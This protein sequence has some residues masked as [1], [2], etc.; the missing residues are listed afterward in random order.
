VTPDQRR[1]LEHAAGARIAKTGA[2]TGGCIGE[3]VRVDLEGGAR[4]VAK[5]AGADGTLEVE[6]Y[7]LAYLGEHS[8]LPVP[9]V[10]LAAPD[11]LVMDYIEADGR[12]DPAAE[13]HAAELL[14]ALHGIAG[15]AFGHERDTLIGPLP[16]PNPWTASWRE[17]LR[18]QRF[19]YM[20]R[21][22]HDSGRLSGDTFGRLEDFCSTLDRY[23][24]ETATASLIHGD[25]W[26]GN[27]LAGKGRIAGFVDPAIYHADPE[28][29][30]AFSTLFSTFGDAFFQ[31]YNEFRPIA[32]GFFEERRH[33]YNL[34]PLLVHTRLF[35]G[36]Y[37]GSVDRTL[38]RFA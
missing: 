4:L 21:L 38:R 9:S 6:G 35:G 33:I 37:G 27:V 24:P 23:I 25:M 22:A 28:I 3:V 17:F 18:D 34:Y 20:G 31:R 15:Q 14:A 10:L 11:L 12:I 29:E 36:H 13:R 16:Q 26:G 19:L 1:R 30:L 5:T 32:P 2:L 8:D 7:M